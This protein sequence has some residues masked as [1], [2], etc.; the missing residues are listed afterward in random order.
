[1]GY[2]MRYIFSLLI[3]ITLLPFS[4]L[5][6]PVSYAGARMVMTEFDHNG[7]QVWANYSPTAFYSLGAFTSTDTSGAT[8]YDTHG[9]SY[10]HLL[11]R[12]NMPEAQANIFLTA[13]AGVAEFNGE[14]EF[15]NSY[16]FAADYET[17][18][19]Y[20]AYGN[21]LKYVDNVEKTFHQKFRAGFAPI[22][23]DYG[24]AQPWLILQAE[25]HPTNDDQW[26]VTP[27]LRVYYTQTLAEFGISNN[28]DVL[29]NLT[30]QF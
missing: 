30:L 6:R 20:F 25:H 5:A 4:A 18:E 22:L 3:L 10:S 23:G 7:R 15:A 21:T 28:K 12:W 19:I 2:T 1:M 9:I 26:V 11:K 24:N 29:F 16:D 13:R 14:T 8:D 27:L 17:R